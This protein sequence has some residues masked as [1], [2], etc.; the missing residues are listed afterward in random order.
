[1]GRRSCPRTRRSAGPDRARDSVSPEL[2]TIGVPVYNGARYLRQ[3]VDSLLSQTFGDFVLL[4]SDNASTDGTREIAESYVKLDARVRYY[5]HSS[6]V[7][8][9]GNY[10]HLMRS[11]DT[12]YLKIANADDFWAP[13]MIA[14]AVSRLESDASIAL[15]Y[16]LM[17]KVDADGRPTEQYDYRLHLVED[18]PAVR[19]RRVLTEIRLINHLTGVI[20][21][22][23]I[24]RTLPIPRITGFDRTLV[25]EL[26]LYGKIFQLDEYHYFRRFHEQASSHLRGSEA[27]QVAYVLPAGAKALRFEAWRNHLGL[28]RR[29]ARSPLHP[30]SKVSVSAWLLRR[31]AWDRRQLAMELV[32]AIRR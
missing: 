6:N 26:S 1:M 28:L 29:V 17:T 5:R 7:G 20:R 2:V 13:T 15:C 9:Y 4:I 8:M 14:D 12:R 31:A 11:A 27:H 22:E 16:P 32:S 24:R 30:V 25:A 23:A 21:T 10:E 19:F 18:D 3:C